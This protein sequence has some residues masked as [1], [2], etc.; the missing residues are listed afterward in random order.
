MRALSCLHSPLYSAA[1]SVNT[2]PLKSFLLAQNLPPLPK[3][4]GELR[5]KYLVNIP[6]M[7]GENN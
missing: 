3:L 5:D 2:D 7:I 6:S 4:S 1:Q